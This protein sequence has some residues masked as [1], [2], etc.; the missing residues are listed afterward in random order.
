MIPDGIQHLAGLG[1]I[2]L[3]AQRVFKLEPRF[4]VTADPGQ[5]DPQFGLQRNIFGLVFEGFTKM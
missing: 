3:Q 2:R 4:P 5:R 1:L